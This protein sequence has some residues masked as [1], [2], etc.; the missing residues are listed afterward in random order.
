[1][2]SRRC[3][4]SN[5]PRCSGSCYCWCWLSRAWDFMAEPIRHG[6]NLREAATR[7]GIALADWLD[8]STG[9]NPRAY[10]VSPVPVD[11]WRR[12]PEDA[13]GFA[14]LAAKHYRAPGALPV[15]GSQAA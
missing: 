5:A 8:L 11:A 2:W 6:G 4:W 9:I 3:G 1:M 10:P 7:Y 13:D 12:L 14:E 15:A